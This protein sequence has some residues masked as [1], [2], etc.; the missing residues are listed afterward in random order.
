MFPQSFASV[1][2]FQQFTGTNP[3]AAVNPFAGIGGA[4]PYGIN[5]VSASPFGPGI[6]PQGINPTVNPPVNP[7]VV[8]AQLAS[9]QL[10][11]QLAAQ[12]LAAHQL[13][14]QQL[15]A[16]QQAAQQLAAVN[17]A[18]GSGLAG[19]PGLPNSFGAPGQIG[20]FGPTGINPGINPLPPFGIGGLPPFL[21]AQ[22]QNPFIQMLPLGGGL[23]L[24]TANPMAALTQQGNPLA[25]Q[26][27]IRPLMSPQPF[28]QSQVGLGTA[29]IGHNTDPYTALA[30]A[31]LISQLTSR[32][33]FQAIN[34]WSYSSRGTVGTPLSMQTTQGMPFGHTGIPSVV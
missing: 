27:P 17:P 6:N 11:A 14:V 25:Q 32:W 33:Q 8:A 5:P 19:H 29:G 3:Y 16:Q 31:H 26:L 34:P 12:Q 9:A 4:S 28:E 1:N 7:I 2:P 22:I 24:A 10:A 18:F 20:Q 15:V 23:P 21:A 30:Q 13:A